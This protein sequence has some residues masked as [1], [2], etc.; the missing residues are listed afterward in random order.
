MRQVCLGL[1]I[2][3]SLVPCRGERSTWVI[4]TASD[5]SRA[6]LNDVR[7]HPDSLVI[8]AP[9]PKDRN[10]ALGHPVMDEFGRVVPLT[11]G[12]IES[13]WISGTPK[14][15]GRKFILDLGMDRAIWR[16]RILAGVGGQSQPEYF[17][18]G[19]RLETSTQINPDYWRIFAEE[20]KNL[21]LD[22]D[23]E[24]DSTWSEIDEFG[25]FLP[26]LGRFVRLELISQ[27]RSN[28]VS[29][30]EL[31]VFGTGFIEEGTITGEFSSDVPVNVG[32]VRWSGNTPGSTRL[33]LQFQSDMDPGFP[34]SQKGSGGFPDSLFQGIEPVTHFQYLGLLRT[35]DPFST[36][37]LQRIEV[38]YDP[39]LVA[40]EV[41]TEVIP[42]TVRKG[43]ETTVSFSA[44][45]VVEPED[46]GIDLVRFDQLCLEI[47]DLRV[48]GEYLQYGETLD[49]GFRW[50]CNPAE[51]STV[52]ELAF[53]DRIGES[54]ELEVMGSALFLKNMNR[55]R[56]QAGSRR[57]AERDGY[58]NWQNVSEVEVEAIGL[59]LD[60]LEEVEVDPGL[61]SPF[62][63]ESMSFR[64]VVGSLRG[65]SEIVV[66]IFRLDGHRVRR[67]VQEGGAR[68]YH[69]SWNGRDR[70]GR[71]VVPGLYLYEVRVVSGDSKVNRRG[72]FT[73]A[74]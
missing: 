29:L 36:P 30:G 44:T 56:L 54:A 7:I 47:K 42:D 66:D 69:F 24:S 9:L 25:N 55:V 45:I 31:E 12:N 64:F 33:E 65:T 52:V 67:L 61:F 41:S 49:S 35:V 68:A 38:E 4:E 53:S 32:R 26:R 37:A 48:N 14:V 5:F 71:I 73:V 11:D 17:I 16:V 3:I 70:D 58:V 39:L 46:Y 21:K 13:E 19:Y 72:T 63:D 74:Y 34:E 15:L 23:T 62:R 20:P 18:R 27:D 57:Q 43:E 60:L 8:L 50:A 51:E 1:V 40:R 10:L 22:I 6:T 2:L 59:P 28:W